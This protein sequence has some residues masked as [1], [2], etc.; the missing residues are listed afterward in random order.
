MISTYNSDTQSFIRRN[1]RAAE[2]P[3]AIQLIK[4]PPLPLPLSWGRTV[5]PWQPSKHQV[6]LPNN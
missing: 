2:D 3:F 4:I 6:R 1:S 5:K